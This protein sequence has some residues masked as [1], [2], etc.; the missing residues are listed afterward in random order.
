MIH[1]AIQYAAVMHKTQ[2]RKGTEVPYIVHPFEVAQILTAA[3]ADEEV[4]CAG[5]LHDVVE[6]TDA[7][8][9]DILREFG[10]RVARVVASESEDKTKSWEQRKQHT[11]N[12]LRGGA[13]MDTMLVACADK[14]S[15]LR[16]IRYDIACSGTAVWNRFARGKE[17]LAWYYG[18]LIH[19][20]GPL[21]DYAMYMELEEIYEEIF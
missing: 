1:K 3:G 9:E 4:I 17:K 7:T 15:N 16:S 12:Y 20:L 5:L 13:D 2:E 6:D 19:A 21:S 10:G 18:E 14:L 11:V 8:V